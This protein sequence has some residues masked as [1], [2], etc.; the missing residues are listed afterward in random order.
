MRRVF[1]QFYVQH[2]LAGTDKWSDPM[3]IFEYPSVRDAIERAAG[4]FVHGTCTVG[5]LYEFKLSRNG[6]TVHTWQRDGRE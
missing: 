3:E 6:V 4:L 2:R 1:P 5:K